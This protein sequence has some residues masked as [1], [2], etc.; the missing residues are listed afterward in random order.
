MRHLITVAF[1]V[2][3][4][5]AYLASANPALT[6]AGWLAGGLFAAGISFE[7]VFWLRLFRREKSSR[8]P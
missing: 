6:G 1:L 3:A 8:K 7:L 5:A 4:F 2:A